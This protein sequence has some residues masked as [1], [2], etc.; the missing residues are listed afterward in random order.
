MDENKFSKTGATMILKQN[1]DGYAPIHEAVENG[2][3]E[4]VVQ[5]ITVAFANRQQIFTVK[6]Q[7]GQTPLHL[8]ALKGFFYFYKYD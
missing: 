3:K 1:K 8:A 6:N 4:I 7:K 2:F 5:F